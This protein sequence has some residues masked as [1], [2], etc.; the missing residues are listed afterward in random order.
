ME[1][2]KKNISLKD[3]FLWFEYQETFPEFHFLF[4]RMEIQLIIS[5]NLYLFSRDSEQLCTKPELG[6]AFHDKQ[7][8]ILKTLEI[9]ID[10][11]Y[12]IDSV[13]TTTMR[14]YGGNMV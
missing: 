6:H 1:W 7:C 13:K 9:Y 12:L 11:M 3:F 4:E 5:E 8:S 10:R 14:E 2:N